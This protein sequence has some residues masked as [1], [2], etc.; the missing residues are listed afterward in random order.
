MMILL[1]LILSLAL[2]TAAAESYD[3]STIRLL[4]Y[5]G[6]VEILDAEG[7]SRFVLENVRFQSGET[8]RT[9]EDGTASVGLDDTKIVTLD[10]MSQVAFTQEGSHMQL[11][12]SEGTLFLDVQ[13]KLDAN[14]TLDIQTST[15]IVGIRGTVVAISD[16]PLEQDALI[17]V[18]PADAAQAD[19]NGAS[20]SVSVPGSSSANQAPAPAGKPA[21]PEA[22]KTQSEESEQFSAGPDG[23]SEILN[24]DVIGSVHGRLSVISVLEGVATVTYRDTDGVLHTIQVRAGEKAVLT[25]RLGDGQPD[26]TPNPETLYREDIEGFATNQVEGD[27]VLKQRVENASDVLTKSNP[28]YDN[29]VVFTAASAEK[30]FD[31]NSFDEKDLK[32]SA[33]G[34]PGDYTFSAVSTGTQVE[35]GSSENV[36]ESYAIYDNHGLDVT[37]RFRKVSTEN[38]ILAVTWDEPVTLIA[39]SASKMYDGTPLTRTSDVLVFGLPPEFRISVFA[40]GSQTDAGESPNPVG[41]YTIYNS[42][43]EDVTEFFTNVIKVPGKLVVDPAP[44]TIW[45]ASDEKP[46]DGTPL[47][48]GNARVTS[49]PGYEYG[50]P[51]WR[52]LSYVFTEMSSEI[53]EG[54]DCQTLYGICGMV[55]VHGTNPLTGESRDIELHAGQKLLV[56]LHDEENVQSIEFKLESVFETDLP[57]EILR[58]FSENPDL[59]KQACADAAWNPEVIEELIA[60]LPEQTDDEPMVE[61]DGLMVRESEA[62][63]LM[64]DFTNV[65]ITI[66]TQITDYSDRALGHEEAH[67]TPVYIDE[68]IR[69]WATGTQTEVGQSKNTY[70]INW[71]NAKPKNYALNPDLGTL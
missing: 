35:A 15:M 59:M 61:Q 46:Y 12:L 43:D 29:P 25:D 47:T 30:S 41:A 34:L 10:T 38:G 19:G 50:M 3:A 24:T 28:V 1:T 23:L 66:D 17:S 67:Y 42:E 22:E 4:R 14:E 58:L 57:E 48:N 54:L 20:N 9:G 8:M 21:A 63:R 13:Q 53:G 32:V 64:T 52:N 27:P 11:T 45:T 31:G 16:F 70:G 18:T 6:T 69:V 39:Q 36:V 55:W 44:L 37:A 65:T 71:G 5:E 56:Y 68:T 49:A 51:R 7:E 2:G 40:E 33:Q 60:A 26:E 62:E